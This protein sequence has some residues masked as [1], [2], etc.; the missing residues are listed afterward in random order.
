MDD[1]VSQFTRLHVTMQI[2]EK[3]VTYLIG[4]FTKQLSEIDSQNLSIKKDMVK[5]VH[6]LYSCVLQCIRTKNQSCD[7]LEL[8]PYIDDYLEYY[9]NIMQ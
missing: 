3:D 9:S 6:E 4:C 2:I 7:L 5:D 1:L 8:M